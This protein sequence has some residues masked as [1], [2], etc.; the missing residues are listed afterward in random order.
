VGSSEI[1]TDGSCIR[2]RISNRIF[3]F[4]I[5]FNSWGVTGK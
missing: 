5:G 3:I 2:I 1:H 4:V